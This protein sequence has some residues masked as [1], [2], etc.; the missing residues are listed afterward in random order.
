MDQLP[1]LAG[2]ATADLV[3]KIG[4]G[5]FSASYINWSRTL[6]LLR[7]HAP[8]WMPEL[9][10]TQDGG[11]LHRAPAG[12]YLLLRFRHLDGRTTPEVPQAVMDPR[13]AAI[14]FDKITA[15]DITD[16]HRRG[17]CMAAAFTFGLAYELWA[18]VSLES[19]YAAEQE[20]S[21]ETDARPSAEEARRIKCSELVEA[22]SASV[23]AIRNGID[24]GDFYTAAEAWYELPQ[25]VMRGLWVAPSKGG[26]FTTK[27]REAMRTDE[28]TKYRPQQD[29]AA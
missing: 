2:I 25:D 6:N 3:E 17:V 7:K 4:G 5:N 13:N 28:F 22:Y 27:Q 20:S 26:P 9:V 18:K 29:Q 1:N 11:V 21:D 14:S 19:G 12:G 10:T 15:R 8:G 16:T 24:S 23:D